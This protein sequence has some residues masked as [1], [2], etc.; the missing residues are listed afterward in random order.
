MAKKRRTNFNK[1][2]SFFENYQD[3]FYLPKSLPKAD[4]CWFAFPLTIKN[5]APFTRNQ[6][7]EFL[8]QQRI[9]GRS[10]FAGN[11]TRH[12]ALRGV[13]YKVSGSLKNSDLILKNTF[14]IGVWP[15]LNNLQ[16]NYVK[17]VFRGFLRK[18]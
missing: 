10:L 11:I 2:Y 5:D 15:G 16:L 6:V 18:H 3:F 7:L 13:N 17:E 1:F 14:F 8:E 12:P 9:E 4:P